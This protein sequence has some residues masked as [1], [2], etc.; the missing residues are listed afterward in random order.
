LC[1]P[2]ATMSPTPA[3]DGI[4]KLLAFSPREQLVAANGRQGQG[5]AEPRTRVRRWKL[6]TSPQFSRRSRKHRSQTE[7]SSE[8][9]DAA[10]GFQDGEW[11]D[12]GGLG[13]SR[14]SS[15]P[16]A[17]TAQS[18]SAP[19]NKPSPP[20]TPYPTTSAKPSPR[21]TGQCA[22]IWP[23]SGYT[24]VTEPQRLQRP[25]GLEIFQRYRRRYSQAGL[26]A[27]VD[28][29]TIRRSTVTGRVDQRYVEALVSI[30]KDNVTASTRIS[31]R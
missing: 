12:G 18:R 19:D 10:H 24:K 2:T 25:I 22:P 30:S 20:P 21:S 7:T 31:I 3:L 8:A 9:G 5:L 4:S 27:L 14:N 29:R 26:A 23:K 28:K 17:A 15:V 1:P 13:A 16:G 11:G 6:G